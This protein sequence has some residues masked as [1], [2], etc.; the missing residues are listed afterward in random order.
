MQ[1]NSCVLSIVTTLYSLGGSFISIDSD[2]FLAEWFA[3]QKADL[4]SVIGTCIVVSYGVCMHLCI[5]L[6]LSVLSKL[7]EI[8]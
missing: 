6:S 1:C 8:A 2:A 3:S 7:N 5:S 4:Q